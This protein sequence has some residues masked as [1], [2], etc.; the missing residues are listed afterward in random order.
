MGI[1][2]I[3][4]E[5]LN[6]PLRE[7]ALLAAA[8]WESIDDPSELTAQPAEEEALHLALSRDAEI[9]AGL[10]HALS[11]DDLMRRLRR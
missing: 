10:I 7:R 4:I 11:H 1:D 3:A 5:A 8:L 9:E 2:P 6:L